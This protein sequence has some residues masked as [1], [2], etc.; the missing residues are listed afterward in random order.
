MHV[1]VKVG[2]LEPG[3]QTRFIWIKYLMDA[4]KK[5]AQMEKSMLP[6]LEFTFLDS[7]CWSLFE[8]FVLC[9]THFFYFH[10][11]PLGFYVNIGHTWPHV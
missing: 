9:N 7:N 2:E 6:L 3:R 5:T 8:N 10:K 1:R 11:C 4:Q